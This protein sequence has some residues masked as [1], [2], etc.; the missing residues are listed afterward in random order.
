MNG[1]K[2]MNFE[3][4]LSGQSLEKLAPLGLADVV[5]GMS[6]RASGVVNA[7]Q[8]A[9]TAG[10]I[11]MDSGS[12]ISALESVSLEIEDIRCVVCKFHKLQKTD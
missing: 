2:V 7:M 1:V 10:E 9:L 3:N 12:I 8:V 11:Q 6:A 5:N 4:R